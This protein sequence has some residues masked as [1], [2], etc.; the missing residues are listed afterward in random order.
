M[1]V[2][3]KTVCSV[4]RPD[5][6]SL[7]DVTPEGLGGTVPFWRLSATA[8]AQ[9][10]VHRQK[11][12]SVYIIWSDKLVMVVRLPSRLPPVPYAALTV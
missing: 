9:C 10:A 7:E 3:Q 8:A 11:D 2:V 5:Y 6:V 4:C 1:C 12:S